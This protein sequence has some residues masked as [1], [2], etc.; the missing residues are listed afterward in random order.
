MILLHILFDNNLVAPPAHIFSSLIL[1]L[2][3]M[4]SMSLEMPRVWLELQ[5][6]VAELLQTDTLC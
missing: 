4:V 2:V 3:L 6:S 1:A 5:P